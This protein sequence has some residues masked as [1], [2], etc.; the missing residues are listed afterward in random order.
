MPMPQ[1][2]LSISKQQNANQT[3]NINNMTFS[4]SPKRYFDTSTSANPMRRI[5]RISFIIDVR[6]GM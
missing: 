1:A 4:V 5:S 2:S 3:I 6:N